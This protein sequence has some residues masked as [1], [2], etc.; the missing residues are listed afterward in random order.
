VRSSIVSPPE[1]QR[2]GRRFAAAGISAL[3]IHDRYDPFGTSPR[4]AGRPFFLSGRHVKSVGGDIAIFIEREEFW[5]SRGA[6]GVP[7]AT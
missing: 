2:A 7:G 3:F 5:R 6:S 4:A 1:N